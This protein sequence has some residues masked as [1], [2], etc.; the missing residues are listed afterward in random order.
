MQRRHAPSNVRYYPSEMP[1]AFYPSLEPQR[2]LADAVQSEHADQE[3]LLGAP[4][5]RAHREDH[6]PGGG[7]FLAERPRTRFRRSKPLDL[8]SPHAAS[9]PK[10]CQALPVGEIAQRAFTDLAVLAVALAQEDGGR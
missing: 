9:S 7:V 2:H 3:P 1:A 6:A 8:R 4:G 10:Q 5:V